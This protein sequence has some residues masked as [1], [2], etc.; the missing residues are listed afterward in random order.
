[1]GTAVWLECDQC[2]RQTAS[3]KKGLCP[4]CYRKQWLQTEGGQRLRER[5]AQSRKTPITQRTRV[6]NTDNEDGTSATAWFGTLAKIPEDAQRAIFALWSAGRDVPEIA[7]Q[8]GIH[9]NLVQTLITRG[10]IS[11]RHVPP[12]RCQAC[13]NK[14]VTI[15]C[16]ICE[17]KRIHRHSRKLREA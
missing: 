3:M 6:R 13:R 8:V 12:Y 2:K 15:P 14:V 16:F 5:V 7:A 4:R 11:P 1:M 10:I 9:T 17:S